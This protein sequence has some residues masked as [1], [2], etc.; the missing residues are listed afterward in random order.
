MSKSNTIQINHEGWAFTLEKNQLMLSCGFEPQATLPLSP[1]I[2]RRKTRLGPWRQV[3]DEYFSASVQ[4]IGTAHLAVRQ[5]HVAFW[6][7]S[8]IKQ[9][10]TVSYFP[11]TTF[12]GTH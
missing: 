4:R 11:G 9:F 5:G 7:E 10:E 2:N 8:K 6:L 3:A 1:M 12:C